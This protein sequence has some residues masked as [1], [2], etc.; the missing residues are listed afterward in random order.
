MVDCGMFQGEKALRLRNWEAPDFDPRGVQALVLTHT[1]LDHIG[2]V[3]RLVKAGF[4]GP[5]YCTPPTRELAEILLKDAAHLQEEDAAYLNRKK[6]TKHAPA[7]PLFDTGDV[8]ACLERFRTVPLGEARGLGDEVSFRFRDAGHL[9]G[10]ASVDMRVVNGGS[11]TRVV[12]SGDVG[13]FD[14]VL[15]KDPELA[16]EADYL[17]VESTYGNRQHAAVPI[18]DQ[19]QGVLERTFARRGILLIPAF[20]VGRA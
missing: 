2:R 3:P 6:L 14:A 8:E 10:A 4:E 12:F 11:E 13:R 15:A 16:P 7:L 9:L 1:H 19:F 5:I 18:E 17:V 20:A